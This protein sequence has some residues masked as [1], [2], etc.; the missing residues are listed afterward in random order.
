MMGAN[1]GDQDT[2]GKRGHTSSIKLC[3][4]FVDQRVQLTLS[5]KEE[6]FGYLDHALIMCEMMDP[7]TFRLVQLAYEGALREKYEI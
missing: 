6:V 1:R 5:W 2:Q 7:Y 4:M 3:S